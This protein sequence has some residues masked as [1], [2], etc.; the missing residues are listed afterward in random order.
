MREIKFR[1]WQPKIKSMAMVESFD[2]ARQ[3]PFWFKILMDFQREPGR[4]NIVPVTSSDINRKD[5]PD[6]VLMQY[7]GLKD[8]SRKEI[9]QFDH[10]KGHGAGFSTTHSE[11]HFTHE[12]AQIEIGDRWIQLSKFNFK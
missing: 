1:V 11:V 4:E 3:P 5:E 6:F 9:W 12:G 7:T 2:C 8:K 10:I